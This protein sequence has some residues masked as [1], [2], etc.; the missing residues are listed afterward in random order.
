MCSCVFDTKKRKKKNVFHFTVYI[1]NW[2]ETELAEIEQ[3]SSCSLTIKP[4][5]IKL[6]LYIISVKIKNGP[7]TKLHIFSDYVILEY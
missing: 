7:N 3:P 2:K 6:V 1:V 4:A 5:G